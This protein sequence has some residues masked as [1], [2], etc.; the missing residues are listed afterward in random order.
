[1]TADPC[2]GGAPLNQQNILENPFI[3]FLPQHSNKTAFYM[4]DDKRNLRATKSQFPD[5]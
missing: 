3:L 5:K 1:M 2:G 4:L